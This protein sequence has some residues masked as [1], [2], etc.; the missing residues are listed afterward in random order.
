[1]AKIYL[2]R[3]AESEFNVGNKDVFNAPLTKVGKQQAVALTGHYNKVLCSPLSRTQ[4]T[5]H[6]SK[7]RVVSKSYYFRNL[8]LARELTQ[9]LYQFNTLL[10]RYDFYG[11][12][13][14]H[15]VIP[16]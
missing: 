11:I 10:L 5:L 12:N 14:F 7:V 8:L 15:S 1:M 2:L 4:Q 16:Y 13:Y 6:L 3:H 9:S